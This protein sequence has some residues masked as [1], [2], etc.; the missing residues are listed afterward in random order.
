MGGSTLFSKQE[1]EKNRV[2]EIW[3]VVP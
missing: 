3:A 2:V 1:V